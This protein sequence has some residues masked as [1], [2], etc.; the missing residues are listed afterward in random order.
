MPRTTS[1]AV[2][3]IIEVDASINLDAFIETASS[4]VDEVCVGALMFNGLP[5]TD[6]KLELIERWLSAHF[7]A[8]RDPRATQEGAGPVNAS[9][10]SRVDLGFNITRY[11]QQALLMDT[12]GG[13]AKLQQQAKDG[14]P[15][16][17][18]KMTW[19]GDRENCT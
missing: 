16:V 18:G 14:G 1:G 6:I 13:L 5:Y 17:K 12:A 10:E 9:Y 15:K 7:Y 19:L 3:A 2:A 11:G 8:V 4:I